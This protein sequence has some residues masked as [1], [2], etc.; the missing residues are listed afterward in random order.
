MISRLL[1]EK[2]A[3]EANHVFGNIISLIL[4]V[5]IA[6]IVLGLSLLTPILYLFGASETMLPYA[7]DYLGIILYGTIFFAFGFAMNNIVRSEGNAKTAMITMLISAGLNIILTPIFIFSFG[8]GIKG[9]AIA[10]VVSQGVTAVYLVWYF[11]MG[12]ALYH[13]NPLI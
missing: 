13:L 6:G 10:T 1:G 12:K 3:D 4:I 7:Q 9:S 5:S 2:K 8:L 11:A